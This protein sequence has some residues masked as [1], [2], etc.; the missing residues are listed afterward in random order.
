MRAA[1]AL[2]ATLL[3]THGGQAAVHSDGQ[4]GPAVHADVGV[5]A[6]GAIMPLK[7]WGHFFRWCCSQAQT[8]R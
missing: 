8:V 1:G 6:I 7:A 4:S 3:R 2:P 5:Q